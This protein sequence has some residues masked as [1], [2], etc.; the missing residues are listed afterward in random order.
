MSLVVQSL[1]RCPILLFPGKWTHSMRSIQSADNNNESFLQQGKGYMMT[2][3]LHS[4]SEDSEQLPEIRRSESEKVKG[5]TTNHRRQQEPLLPPATRVAKV[6][7]YTYYSAGHIESR[8]R[9]TSV[10]NVCPPEVKSP[11]N[12]RSSLLNRKHMCRAF[13][14]GEGSRIET[15]M[16]GK[17]DL[18]VVSQERKHE[19]RP[20]EMFFMDD[21]L[22]QLAP[23]PRPVKPAEIM[24]C[25]KVQGY[26]WNDLW[27]GI[28][29][30]S[31]KFRANDPMKQMS[32]PDYC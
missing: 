30:G 6:F 15:R 5:H 18:S 26:S 13:S 9:E 22:T 31:N 8:S 14:L 10:T 27:N 12:R 11:L 20:E 4:G 23:I 2:Y 7:P 24:I 25:R 1:S 17:M 19:E 21:E 29:R 28:N 16:N 32:V 3:W